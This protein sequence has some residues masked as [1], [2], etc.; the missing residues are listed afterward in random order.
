MVGDALRATNGL[1]PW[2]VPAVVIAM[3]GTM[4]IF[5]MKMLRAMRAG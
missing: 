2:F 1:G 5:G 3:A 4:G